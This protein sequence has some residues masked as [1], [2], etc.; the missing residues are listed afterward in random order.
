MNAMESVNAMQDR[1]VWY[2]TVLCTLLIVFFVLG[3]V[4]RNFRR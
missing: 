3:W 2:L 1:M 4:G